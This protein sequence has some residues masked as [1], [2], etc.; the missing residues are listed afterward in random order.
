MERKG[1]LMKYRKRTAALL[2]TLLF[3]MGLTA[4]GE[5]RPE[6]GGDNGQTWVGANENA[7]AFSDQGYYYLPTNQQSNLSYLDISTGLTTVLCS[8][9]GCQH[10]SEEVCEAFVIPSSV[11]GEGGMCFWNDSLYYLSLTGY[12]IDLVRRNATGTDMAV[13]GTLGDKYIA[14]QKSVQTK[15]FAQVAHFWYYYAEVDGS[16]WNENAQQ[17]ESKQVLSYI[18]R[19]DLRTGKEEILIEETDTLNFYAAKND[20]VLFS[21]LKRPDADILDRDAYRE[22]L[23]ECPVV[24]KRWDAQTGQVTTLLEKAHS[25]FTG[26]QGVF[27]GKLYY[28][29]TVDF[30]TNLYIYD[31]E[32]GEDAL[33]ADRESMWFWSG[34]YAYCRD[35][36]TNGDWYI[37]ELKSGKKLPNEIET[38]SIRFTSGSDHGCI[39]ALTVQPGDGSPKEHRMCYVSYAALADGLQEADLMNF[40]TWRNSV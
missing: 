22:Q 34:G 25:E 33:L 2:L 32:T 27:D 14:D 13:I 35:Q 11:F 5:E 10:N 24:L 40:Y 37:L 18:S 29:G 36:E 7:G 39:L 20:A 1:K 19:I 16:V 38:G 6:G 23:A 30:K 21:T 17:Y 31:L 4:C 12:G 26:L 3:C 8:K 28:Y 15:V 9:A